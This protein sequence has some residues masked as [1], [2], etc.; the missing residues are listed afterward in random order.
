KTCVRQMILC[1]VFAAAV[2]T[3]DVNRAITTAH[4]LK[5]GMVCVN[6]YALSNPNVPFGGYKQSDIG[7]EMGEY[8]LAKYVLLSS[9]R[10]LT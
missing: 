8:A 10:A 4:K 9:H 5:A 6:R 3:K 1:T 7:R 2:F